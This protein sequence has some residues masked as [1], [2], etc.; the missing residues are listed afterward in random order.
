MKRFIFLKN[1]LLMIIVLLV[2][3]CGQSYTQS[4]KQLGEILKKDGTIDYSQNFIGSIDPNGYLLKTKKNGEP[5]FIK[6][7]NTG[8]AQINDTADYRWDNQFYEPGVHVGVIPH[9]VTAMAQDK[10]NVYVGGP[11][12][13]A[14]G[15]YVGFVAKWNKKSQRWSQLGAGVSL[16][17]DNA[18]TQVNTIEVAADGSIFI[19]G[20]FDR[21][22]NSPNDQT[23][24]EAYNIAAWKG[25]HWE[26]LNGVRFGGAYYYN[27]IIPTRN[28][29]TGIISIL[30]D[31]GYG[32]LFVGGKFYAFRQ[33]GDTGY[34]KI[35]SFAIWNYIINKWSTPVGGVG[36][37]AANGSKYEGWV[38]S[39]TFALKTDLFSGLYS[40]VILG[41]NFNVAIG[42]TLN[43]KI[44]VNNIVGY[45][46]FNYNFYL[47]GKGINKT[48]AVNISSNLDTVITSMITVGDSIFI[49]GEFDLID[50]LSTGK[51]IAIYNTSTNSWKYIEPLNAKVR[52][53]YKINK[54]D[55]KIYAGG[56]FTKGL[57]EDL[58]HIALYNL[59][60]SKWTKIDNNE[61]IDGNVN[62]IKANV[63]FT[64][65]N[66]LDV[67]LGGDFR[68]TGSN[69]SNGFAIIEPS[70]LDYWLPTIGWGIGDELAD[71]GVFTM[72]KSGNY[73]FVGGFFDAT[74]YKPRRNIAE[75]NIFFN[76]WDWDTDFDFNG[77]DS[78]V[79]SIYYDS[80]KNELWIVGD[81]DTLYNFD[82][83]KVVSKQIGKWSRNDDLW[84]VVG[85]G[86]GTDGK[87]N[88]IFMFNGSIFVA[89]NFKTID[90]ISANSAARLSGN[91]WVPL[92]TGNQ[93]GSPSDLFGNIN[94]LIDYNGSLVA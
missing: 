40:K 17:F 26:A 16:S 24:I 8:F 13:F 59:T 42:T 12:Y 25:D 52:T 19:G 7:N 48:S 38:T 47:L 81:F 2:I 74:G 63:D 93:N 62:V 85:N 3:F 61:I 71:N 41:G 91:T 5:V 36:F 4:K 15:K 83:S 92:E 29:N 76:S 37:D 58:S 87:V 86:M 54:P 73:L 43:N 51:N 28:Y 55:L 65:N 66:N 23:G 50:S 35:N 20:V 80:N 64:N 1:Q 68:K 70:S 30:K 77:V 18:H 33:N 49:G 39:I 45:D 75:Y 79:R 90:N 44:P 94:D 84:H 72:F 32:H 57:V 9:T 11:F 14:G 67:Y 69:I 88:K 31:D 34:R 89:G 46:V 53:L 82:G 60:G 56:D 21:V 78:T 22:F 10:E 27:P 6:N